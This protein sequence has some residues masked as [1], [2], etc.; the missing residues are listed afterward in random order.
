[1]FVSHRSGLVAVYMTKLGSWGVYMW[2]CV[3]RD[4]D[5]VAGGPYI[6][7]WVFSVAAE[8][9]ILSSCWGW[10]RLLLSLFWCD[11]SAI[12]LG[13]LQFSAMCHAA[14]YPSWVPHLADSG[15]LTTSCSGGLAWGWGCLATD[16]LLPHFGFLPCASAAPPSAASPSGFCALDGCVSM[17]DSSLLVYSCGWAGGIFAAPLGFLPCAVLILRACSVR[18][19]P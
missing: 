18:C 11:C 7:V 3:G 9:C 5:V 8:L 10:G 16:V 1:M 14:G 17:S 2:G 4:L 12:F 13:H 15:W 19:F 6:C